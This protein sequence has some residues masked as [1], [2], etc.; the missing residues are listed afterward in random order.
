MPEDIAYLSAADLLCRYREGALSPVEVTAT[1]LQRAQRLQTG[2]N[3]TTLIDTEAAM[4][5][6]EASAARYRAGTAR[7]LEGIPVAIKEETAVAGWPRT[8]GS[9]LHD[10]LPTQHHPIVDRLIDAGAVPHLQTT[11]PEFCVI[12]QTHSARY[13][14][15]R[16]PWNRAVTPGGSSGGSG[17]ALAAGL[18][19]LATGSDMGGSTRIPA[20]LNGVYGYKPPFGRLAAT[21][22][23]ELFAFAVEGPL[24]RSVDDLRLLQ[25]VIQGPHPASYTGMP[26]TPLTDD[27][28]DLTGVRLA[29]T[30]PKDGI[31]CPDT[32]RNLRA[33]AAA[34]AEAGA[35][36]EE[37]TLD[38]DVGRAGEVLIEA[39][40]GLYFAEYL[41]GFTE[42]EKTRAT[43]YLRYLMDRYCGRRN[44]VMA[45]AVLASQMHH[46]MVDKIWSRGVT[47][48]L[49]PTV[50]CTDIPADLDMSEIR[51]WPVA[52]G[53]VDSY[54]GW[55]WTT[56]FNLLS[57]TPSIAA[58]TGLAANGVPT[59]LQIVGAPYA[60]ADV[61]RVAHHY[62]RHHPLSLYRTT[63][64]SLPEVE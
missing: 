13:G 31:I 12:G 36:I 1:L 5:K 14:V 23:E 50:L 39:I 54:L 18:A 55:V 15:S 33:G 26:A 48:L 8:I 16:N 61:F 3:A 62:A 45:S 44:S 37:V 2:L 51:Q 19:P 63:F 22:H 28:A 38:W 21:P 60:D 53:F 9:H 41:E 20:A 52:G 34:L 7:A 56:P 32:E 25:N 49:C 35:V 10:E 17:A 59:S 24:A 27:P 64:P 11:V 4:V 46:E 6:A 30:L 47:A 43:P 58:P 29:L 57:R 40:F 42:E